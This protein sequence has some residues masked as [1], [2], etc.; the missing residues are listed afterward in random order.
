MGQGVTSKALGEKPTSYF[1]NLEKNSNVQKYISNLK[2]VKNGRNN[3]LTKQSDIEN[4]V[5][6]RYY[7]QLY[8][9][10]DENITF[11]D[12]ESFM[13]EDLRI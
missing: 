8:A 12:I 11:E 1:L 6:R 4:E 10:K 13:G 7:Q 5:R 2:V 9:N 3:T